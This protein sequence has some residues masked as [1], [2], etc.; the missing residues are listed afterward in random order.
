MKKQNTTLAI[1]RINKPEWIL[2]AIGCIVASLNGAREPGYS[3]VQAKLTAVSASLV[4]FLLAQFFL[5]GKVFEEC[6]KNS[7][8]RQVFVYVLLYL[9]FGVLGFLFNSIQV[10]IL[11]IFLMIT[12][13]YFCSGP[14]VCLFW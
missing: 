13:L 10:C 14:C 2:I 12:H 8:K 5:F 9:G 6:D 7:Q 3:I 11:I 1:L 4:F